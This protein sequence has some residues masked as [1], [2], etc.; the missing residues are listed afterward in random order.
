M[1]T[2][3]R[4]ISREEALAI[5]E[6]GKYVY[7][8]RSLHQYSTIRLGDLFDCGFAVEIEPEEGEKSTDAPEPPK[9]AGGG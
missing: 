9:E 7:L 3:L 5:L 1:G 8:M 4:M 6:S 2:N